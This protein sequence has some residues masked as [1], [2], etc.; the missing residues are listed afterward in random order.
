V[1][2]GGLL[3]T[4]GV[5]HAPDHGAYHG[6]LAQ[7][8]ELEAIGRDQSDILARLCGVHGRRSGGAGTW[9]ETFGSGS[10]ELGLTQVK[11]LRHSDETVAAD[12]CSQKTSAGAVPR[13][14]PHRSLW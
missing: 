8:D 5:E 1:R 12:T 9:F 7:D 11:S 13:S 6:R 10:E 2:L 3:R 4:P 14:G